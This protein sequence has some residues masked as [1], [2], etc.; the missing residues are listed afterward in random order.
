[1]AYY[2]EPMDQNDRK[3]VIDI[4]NF[5]IEKT[6]AAFPEKKVGYEFF[7]FFLKMTEGYPAITVKNHSGQ[8]FGFAFLRPYH[9]METFQRTA[10]ITYFIM[11]EHTRK[12]IGKAILDQFVEQAKG[13]NIDS[14][15]AS[16]S[17]LNEGS[18]RFHLKCGF[19]ECG[20]FLKI[21]RKFGK[22]FDV[23]WM[24][25]QLSQKS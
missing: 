7:D 16:I 3:P 13:L 18:I 19:K 17:S 4:F 24:Q 5:F 21:G 15:L 20:R 8:V 1:M 23:V 9:K 11:P 12:G 22:D 14:I 25:K 10:E 6:F 2:F